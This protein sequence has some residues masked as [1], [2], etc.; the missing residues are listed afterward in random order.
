[1]SKYEI[2]TIPLYTMYGEET[3]TVLKGEQGDEFAVTPEVFSEDY[4]YCENCGGVYEKDE[5]M[6]V[7]PEDKEYSSDLYEE[8]CENCY[9]KL[10]Q[11]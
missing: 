7:Y 5:M 4:F 6:Y 1:M 11:K 8:V 9:L 3:L 2:K 10:K